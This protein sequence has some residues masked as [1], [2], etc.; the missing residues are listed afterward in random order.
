MSRKNKEVLEIFTTEWKPSHKEFEYPTS[1][2]KWI[3]SINSGWQNKIHYEP[4]ETYCRQAELWVQD[5]S[6]ILDYDTEDEQVEWL[7]REIQRCKDNTLYFC[8]KYGYIKED[9]SENG[10]LAYQAWD[11]QK[12]LLF[13]FDCGY[14]LMIGK[15][16]RLVLP[17]PC[18]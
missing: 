6:E 18:A 7:M 16:D 9:R 2:V 12:V 1:F 14:S 5:D 4:F 11:A 8:N 13:L 15:A 3:D 10:M 17:L